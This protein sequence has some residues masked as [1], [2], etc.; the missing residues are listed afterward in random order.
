MEIYRRI[1]NKTNECDDYIYCLTN[2][3]GGLFW[4]CHG[5]SNCKDFPTIYMGLERGSFGSG[6]ALALS[7][8]FLESDLCE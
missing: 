5:G 7:I 6:T 8:P 4:Q 3:D 2:I 1:I